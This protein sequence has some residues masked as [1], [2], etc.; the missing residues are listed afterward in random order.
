[1]SKSLSERDLIEDLIGRFVE[2]D[3]RWPGTAERLH[4]IYQFL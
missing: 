2:P 1:V 3:R 4:T